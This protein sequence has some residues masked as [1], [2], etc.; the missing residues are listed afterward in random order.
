MLSGKTRFMHALL[1]RMKNILVHPKAEWQVIK[2]ETT[3][4]KQVIVGYVAVLASV[5]LAVSVLEAIV[6]GSGTT[7]S[8]SSFSMGSLLMGYVLWYLMIIIDIV[9]LGAIIN[10]LVTGQ[11]SSQNQ[12]FKIA[13]YSATP[14]MLVGIAH[15]L[16]KAAW[17]AYV[18]ILYSVYLLFLGI[19]SLTAVGQRKAAWLAVSS[20]LAAS[21]IVGI[22]NLFEY[23]FE[24]YL[25]R[26]F[27]LPG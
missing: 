20:F 23:L 11:G 18:A 16:P 21:V 5:P 14:L 19:S 26:K 25:M 9:I 7:G 6:F 8:V 27:M 4:L 1:R 15:S 3:T 22:L 2:D 17:L 13:A 12:G 24:S 10:A